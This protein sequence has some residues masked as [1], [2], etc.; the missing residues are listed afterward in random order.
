MGLILFVH[1]DSSQKG[2]TFRCAIE[3]NFSMLGIQVVQT[4]DALKTRLN[5]ISFYDR[6]IFV[7]FAD[8]KHRLKTLESLLDRLKD[9]RLILVLPDTSKEVLSASHQFYPRFFTYVNNTYNDL[10]DVLN[11]MTSQE[12]PI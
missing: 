4:V 10:C 11:K 12:K 1:Q 8:S 3:K 6:E 7:L 5:Q 9:R 2:E